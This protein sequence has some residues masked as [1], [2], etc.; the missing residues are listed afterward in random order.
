MLDL[1]EFDVFIPS[2]SIA[3][4]YQGQHHYSAD[5]IIGSPEERGLGR[6]KEK[7]ALSSEYG[8]TLVTIPYWWRK[9]IQSLMATVWEI[10]PD[11]IE[12]RPTNASKIPLFAP[13]KT[14]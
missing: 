10:R 13:Q 9:D 2:L 4:E 7:K 1:I 8:I 3:F 5:F 12:T 6:D 11:L 14:K